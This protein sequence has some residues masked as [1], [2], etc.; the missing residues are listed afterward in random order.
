MGVAGCSRTGIDYTEKAFALFN[1][2]VA[3]CSRT[4]IDYTPSRVNRT[5][6]CVGSDEISRVRLIMY[7]APSQ[8]RSSGMTSPSGLT[9]TFVASSP[10]RG[11]RFSRSD[12]TIEKESREEFGILL[13]SLSLRSVAARASQ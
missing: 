3:G 2:I 5:D 7:V 8:S 9:K 1:K 11:V 13:P 4:G 12:G 10:S 6:R